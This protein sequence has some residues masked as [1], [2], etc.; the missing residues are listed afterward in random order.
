MDQATRL[1][2]ILRPGNIRR[3]DAIVAP[4]FIDAVDLDREQDRNSAAIQFAGELI[5]GGSSPAVAEENDAR[6]LLLFVRETAIFICVEPMQDLFQCL[7]S[8]SVFKYDCVRAW[9][10]L[11]FQMLNDANFRVT[12][13]VVPHEAA[14]KTDHYDDRLGG[15]AGRNPATLAGRSSGYDDCEQAAQH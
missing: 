6:I 7:R 1:V 3:N 14:K 15:R 12:V 2:E 8:S 13:I 11:L 9:T 10:S 4:S 5:D